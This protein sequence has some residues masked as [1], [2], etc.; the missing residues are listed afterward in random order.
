MA[1]ISAVVC[2][3]CG[4]LCDELEVD[5]EGNRIVRVRNACSVGATKFL[6]YWRDRPPQPLVKD[7]EGFKPISLEEA[8]DRIATMLVEADYPLIYGWSLTSCEAQKLGVEL[9]ELVGGVLDNNTTVCHGPTILGVQEVGEPTCTLGEV[10][11]RADL[12]I[13]WGCNPPEAHGQHPKRYTLEPRGRFRER[14]ERRLVV[15]DVRETPIARQADRFLRIEPNHDYELL[16]A[17]RL[18]LENEEIEEDEVGGVPVREIEDLAEEMRRCEFG[19]LFFGLGLTMTAGKYRNIDAALRLVRELNRWTKFAIMPMRGHFNV[20]GANKVSTWQTGFPYAVDLSRGHPWYNPG[21]TTA[22]DILARGDNDATLVVAADPVAS[23]PRKAVAHLVSQPL[24]VV[25]PQLSLTARMADIVIPSA[26]VGIEA[27]G[28][29]YRM[30][31]VAL[32]LKKLLEPPEGV[33]PDEV[34]LRRIVDRV[35]A[36]KAGGG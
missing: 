24:A 17:L 9:A 29:A 19:A 10:K 2:P 26:Y 20:T 23:F 34:I 36:L 28:T 16:T 13:Y 35:R 22:V 8:V 31:G 18:A 12:I 21:E 11:A 27:E 25:D 15:V 32:L 14:A 1:T 7:G 3:G 4:A 30:D 5:V 6:N 33:Y